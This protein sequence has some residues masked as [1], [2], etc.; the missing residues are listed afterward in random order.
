M[1]KFKTST[2]MAQ[3]YFGI[4]IPIYL[5]VLFFSFIEGGVTCYQ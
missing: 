5:N 4:D 1:R 3:L 2:I